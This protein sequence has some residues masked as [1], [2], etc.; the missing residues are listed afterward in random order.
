MSTLAVAAFDRTI[1]GRRFSSRPHRPVGLIEPER[2]CRALR[3]VLYALR[4]RLSIEEATDLK[5]TLPK[6]EV[7]KAHEIKGK[8]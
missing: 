1:Q 8:G 6:T 4:D 5:F 3:K 2:A 7:A